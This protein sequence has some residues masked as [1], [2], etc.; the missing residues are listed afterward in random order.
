V[1]E[2]LHSDAQIP[3]LGFLACRRSSSSSRCF[4][5][6]AA[7]EHTSPLIV[8]EQSV[9]VI[10]QR[11]VALQLIADIFQGLA[12]RRIAST[13]K[14]CDHDI[15][16][17]LGLLGLSRAHARHCC[18]GGEWATHDVLVNSFEPTLLRTQGLSIDCAM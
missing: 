1:T 18:F 11:R 12:Y 8:V 6:D 13:R 16:L 5:S 9:D 2:L 10:H 4:A 15:C 3:H 17:L 14:G 7:L